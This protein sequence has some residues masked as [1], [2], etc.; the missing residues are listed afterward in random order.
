M[1]VQSKRIESLSAKTQNIIE[2]VSTLGPHF[3]H[4]GYLFRGLLQQVAQ[5]LQ[6]PAPKKEQDRK[7]DPM[8]AQMESKGAQM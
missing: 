5:G 4:F 8:G 3:P 1:P 7:M 6:A 2:N